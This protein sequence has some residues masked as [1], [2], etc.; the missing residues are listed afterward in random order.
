MALS[1]LLPFGPLLKVL[2]NPAHVLDGFGFSVEDARTCIADRN[3]KFK[4]VLRL[5]PQFAIPIEFEPHSLVLD[6]FFQGHRRLTLHYSTD[7][8][9]IGYR[10]HFSG[11]ST[12]C[13][14][15]D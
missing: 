14:R 2:P 12:R 8:P 10:L 7:S 11:V 13:P 3:R 6:D 15:W 4:S 1:L 5:V 9:S